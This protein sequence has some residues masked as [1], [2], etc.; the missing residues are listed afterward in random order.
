MTIMID[1]EMITNTWTLRMI[2]IEYI[3]T[4]GAIN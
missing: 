3:I 4:V 1:L 2:Y